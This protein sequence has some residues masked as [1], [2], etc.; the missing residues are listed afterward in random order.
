MPVAG[1]EDGKI[2]L[3]L[4]SGVK[5][6]QCSGAG[7]R[8]LSLPFKAKCK[9]KCKKPAISCLCSPNILVVSARAP[10]LGLQRGDRACHVH[11]ASNTESSIEVQKPS[12]RISTPK[13][14]APA[15]APYAHGGGR[16][17]RT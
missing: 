3:L 15:A 8:G 5:V 17:T 12:F 14:L 16:G 11:C 10:W 7:K 13:T 2:L 9:K 1:N 6:K 4:G